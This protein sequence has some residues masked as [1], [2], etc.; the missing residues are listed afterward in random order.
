MAALPYMQFHIA[1]YLAD[2]SHLSTEEHGAYLLLIFNYWQRGKALDNSNGRL[3]NVVRMSNDRW[4]SVAPALAEFFCVQNDVWTHNR[5]E[6]DLEAVT[7]KCA[8]ARNARAQRTSNGRS[9]D[10][11]TDVQRVLREESKSKNNKEQK[12]KPAKAVTVFQIPD[13][14]D[15]ECWAGYLEVRTKKRAVA[16]DR[17]L[18]SVVKRLDEF[19]ARGH[20]PNEVLLTSTRSNWTDVY[21]P[22]GASNGQF[23]GKTESSVNAAQQAINIIRARGQA[24]RD[25]CPADQAGN[26]PPGEAGHGRLLGAG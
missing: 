4:D 9:T 10:V 1:E 19:R 14:I 5:I 7:A 21:E 26:T 3:A 11:G 13:W 24:E 20:D 2:T 23:L 25:R 22:K 6:R 8:Q 18:A 16:S 17:A 12:Q 15:P